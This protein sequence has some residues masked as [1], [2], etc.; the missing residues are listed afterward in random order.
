MRNLEIEAVCRLQSY[1][2][3]TAKDAPQ[4]RLQTALLLSGRLERCELCSKTSVNC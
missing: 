1:E 4:A 3:M 2:G